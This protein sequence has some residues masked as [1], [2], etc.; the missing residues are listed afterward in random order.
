MAES[1]ARQPREERR[2]G[3]AEA[4]RPR[5]RVFSMEAGSACFQNALERASA[6][7]MAIVSNKSM[8]GILLEQGDAWR[9]VSHA[10]P[11]PTSTIVAYVQPGRRLG[12]LIEYT[13][14]DGSR[15]SVPV[16]RE[17]QKEKDAA[18]V[19]ELPY[20]LEKNG[21]ERE[22]L[23]RAATTDLIRHFP[24]EDGWHLGDPGHD[25][26]FGDKVEES[27]PAARQ[28]RRVEMWVGPVGRVLGNSL[29]D[30]RRDI[31]TCDLSVLHTNYVAET[32]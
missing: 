21:S 3:P 23:V 14:Q 20:R 1:V 12:E 24:P 8:S 2:E 30:A 15:L 11:G 32:P 22:S 18:L 29:Y 31:H 5:V 16:P 26:P 7:N 6:E 25:I 13:R 27:D 4:V 17:Y 28:L 10:L 9:A 19:I